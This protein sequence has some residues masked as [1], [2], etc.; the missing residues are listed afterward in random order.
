VGG[1]HQAAADE[2]VPYRRG[3]A[4]DLGFSSGAPG[5]ALAP[6]RRKRRPQLALGA[7]DAYG[8][9]APGP[10]TGAFGVFKRGLARPAAADATHTK[11]GTP[12]ACAWRKAAM[13]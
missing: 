9:G 10:A 7:A 4:G 1:R 2:A 13:R 5:S 6:H 8:D 12:K 11:P 3:A